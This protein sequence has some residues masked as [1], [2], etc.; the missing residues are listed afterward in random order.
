MSCA[1]HAPALA[2]SG[3]WPSKPTKIGSRPTEGS[4]TPNRTSQ[5]HPSTMPGA[6]SV[7]QRSREFRWP[8]QIQH[9]EYISSLLSVRY[10]RQAHC[11]MRFLFPIFKIC[12]IVALWFPKRPRARPEARRAWIAGRLLRKRRGSIRTARRC[13]GASSH[14]DAPAPAAE[15]LSRRKKRLA[16]W[17]RPQALEKGRKKLGFRF[18]W[19]WISFPMIWIFL[20][21]GFGNP[22]T[23]FVMSRHSRETTPLPL[24]FI[25]IRAAGEGAPFPLRLSPLRV[26]TGERRNSQTPRN[27]IND[28]V[29]STCVNLV[30]HPARATATSCRRR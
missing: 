3:P 28:N 13:G 22:S 6:C 14:V 8:S 26:R 9:T 15:A 20:P 10:R 16:I 23:N 7:P 17:I 5:H 27:S 18:P 12:A 21:V 19:L 11:P 30:V 2:S 24:A 4:Q 25:E 29:T 1:T